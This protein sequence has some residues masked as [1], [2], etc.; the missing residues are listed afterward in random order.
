MG[1]DM[2]DYN[3]SAA[4]ILNIFNNIPKIWENA[5][6]E[7][8]EFEKLHQIKLPAILI[9]FMES[10]NLLLETANIRTKAPRLFF[11]EIA[12]TLKHLTEQE[13]TG[14]FSE[15]LPFTQLSKEHW[16]ELI[17][18]YIIIG[19]DYGAGIVD[20]GIRKMDLF[21]E[22]PPVYQQYET[23]SV[24]DDWE[25]VWNHLSEYLLT[26]VCDALM[27]TDY[28]TAREVLRKNGWTYKTYRT[29]PHRDSLLSEYQIDSAKL[30]YIPFV[31]SIAKKD[32]ISCCYDKNRN[33]FFLFRNIRSQKKI[34]VISQ[35]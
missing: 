34:I 35:K 32:Y 9:E 13:L 20:F 16:D 6:E 10:A 5:S 11:D 23:D 4:D 26:V 8:S 14:N 27:E 33:V 1:D 2:I 22:N 21:L 31:F 30:L 25:L 17:D 15:Y 18:E 28:R 29:K 12:Y 24:L 7:L 19:S 3:L